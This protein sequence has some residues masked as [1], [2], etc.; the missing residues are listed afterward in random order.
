MLISYN[1][2]QRYFKKHLPTAEKVA[3]ILTFSVFEV[4]SVEK[5]ETVKGG[6]E[7]CVIGEVKTRE[8]HPDADRLSLTT[9]DIG[10]GML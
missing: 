1:W 4:E 8:K 9:V 6:L 5:Y 3:E 2:L 10:T 7:G